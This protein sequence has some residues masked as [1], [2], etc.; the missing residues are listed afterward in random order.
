[1]KF[2]KKQIKI[3][4]KLN[5]QDG[6]KSI[7][8]LGKGIYSTYRMVHINLDL[9]VDMG[10]VEY[11]TKKNMVIPYLTSYGKDILRVLK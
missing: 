7:T 10:L 4:R 5:S 2:N 6:N 1:M 9:F 11:H 3:L 8:E